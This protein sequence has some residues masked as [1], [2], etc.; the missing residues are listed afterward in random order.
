M[1]TYTLIIIA[2]L[3][4]GTAGYAIVKSTD[5]IAPQTA[6]IKMQTQTEK[7]AEIEAQAEIERQQE[8]LVEIRNAER[9]ATCSPASQSFTKAYLSTTGIQS[10]EETAV[11]G[12]MIECKSDEKLNVARGQ[13]TWPDGKAKGSFSCIDRSIPD[14]PSS[15]S[16][17]NCPTAGAC[18]PGYHLDQS[19]MC[20]V[21]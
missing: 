11:W 8:K 16:N 7:E 13:G 6:E 9:V 12:C 15:S 14:I 1:K 21:D 17:G 20:V 18:N 19:C 2:I 5:V 10:S 4:L 3:V